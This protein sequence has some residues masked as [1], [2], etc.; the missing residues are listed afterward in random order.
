[1]A[2][3]EWGPVAAPTTSGVKVHADRQAC[4]D[5]DARGGTLYNTLVV[6]MMGGAS[7][8]KSMDVDVQ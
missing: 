5:L 3:R 4:V 1:M 8:Q 7:G 6:P 2:L